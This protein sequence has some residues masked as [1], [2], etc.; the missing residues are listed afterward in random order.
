[1]WSS[2]PTAVWGKYLIIPANMGS[3]PDHDKIHYSKQA[4]MD[5]AWV[6]QAASSLW[7]AWVEC[8][9]H[10]TMEFVDGE[11]VI[12]HPVH[13]NIKVVKE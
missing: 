13:G 6:T 9:R 7:K 4:T 1:M 2:S 8:L 12:N 5:Y 10:C 3:H 11:W